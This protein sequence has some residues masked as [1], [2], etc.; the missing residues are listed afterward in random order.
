VTARFRITHESEYLYAAPS[1][2][3]YNEVRMTPT[4]TDVQLTLE[5][6]LTVTPTPPSRMLRYWDYWGTA[7]HGFDIHA[8]HD[9]LRVAGRSLVE[10]NPPPMPPDVSWE[11]LRDPAAVDRFTELL[12]PTSWVNIDPVIADAAATLAMQPTPRAA[13]EAAV[14]W[15]GDAMTYEPGATSVQTTAVEALRGGRGVCQ[16]FAHLTLAVLRAMGIPSRYT[17]GYFHPKGDAFIGEPLVG[18]SH[19][20]IEAWT[21]DWWGIDPT[22]GVLAGERHILVGRGRDYSDVPPLKGV[23]T[24]GACTSVNVSVEV[25]RVA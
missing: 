21:G 10:T 5:S 19:A 18:E 15:V 13:V 11:V 25:S 16:D 24:G 7:V 2:A 12:A 9:S 1:T 3:S 8:P 6:T 22:N 17:S 14:G 20:W 23:Y 4:T